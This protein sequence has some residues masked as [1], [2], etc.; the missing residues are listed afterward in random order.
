[1]VSEL[2]SSIQTINKLNLPVSST[3][4]KL[5][6]DYLKYSREKNSLKQFGVKLEQ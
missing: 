2:A 6:P 5:S 3:I 4:I 1:M